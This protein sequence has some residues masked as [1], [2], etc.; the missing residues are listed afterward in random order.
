[1][2]QDP[3]SCRNVT[4]SASLMYLSCQHICWIKAVLS[5]CPPGPVQVDGFLP[6]AWSW[7][8]SWFWFCW[9]AFP[10]TVASSSSG[11]GWMEDKTGCGLLAFLAGLPVMKRLV[12]ILTDGSWL[13]E[14]DPLCCAD[15]T[16]WWIGCCTN[17]AE[18]RCCGGGRWIS[19]NPWAGNNA[20]LLHSGH[21]PS[22]CTISDHS[23]SRR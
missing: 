8:W 6:W 16:L 1:M 12:Q 17:K 10:S 23:W 2:R 4:V 20:W 22:V 15:I 3:F 19:S 7:F 18:L 9:I 14:T 21:L 13:A 11:D 5:F